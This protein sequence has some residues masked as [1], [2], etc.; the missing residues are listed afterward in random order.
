M[1]LLGEVIES[2]GGARLWRQLRGHRRIILFLTRLSN[3]KPSEK[4]RLPR[5]RVRRPT[6]G[7]QS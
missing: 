5:A 6:I 4:K 1:T 2:P 3:T 7:G